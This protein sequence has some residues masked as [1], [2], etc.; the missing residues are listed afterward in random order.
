MSSQGVSKCE[1]QQFG[2]WGLAQSWW[3][4]SVGRKGEIWPRHCPWDSSSRELPTDLYSPS[5]IRGTHK[6]TGQRNNRWMN[7]R[8]IGSFR[9]LTFAQRRP[10]AGPTHQLLRTLVVD[11]HEEH[12]WISTK[13]M[14]SNFPRMT[15]KTMR[16]AEKPMEMQCQTTWCRFSYNFKMRLSF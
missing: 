2:L 7:S 4:S 9:R 6:T 12:D 5:C 13:L 10:K 14:E 8:W 11:S 1:Q 15:L 16:L 3:V